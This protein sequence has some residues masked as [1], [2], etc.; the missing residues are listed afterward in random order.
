M[1]KEMRNR[2]GLKDRKHVDIVWLAEVIFPRFFSQYN[3]SFEVLPVE[4]M[5]TNHGL[6]N[7]D[8]GKVMIREDVYDRAC[9]GKG[10]DR[11]TIAHELGHFLMH[12]GMTF[13]LARASK[14]E[15][16]PPYCDPE[17]QATAF[18]AEFLMD[19]DIIR[20]MSPEEIAKECGVSLEA[21]RYQK[22]KI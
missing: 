10:R 20:N 11:L 17:W 22:G 2:L 13:G 19:S 16:I 3:Y 18:A 6:T 5:G 4:E 1:A 14:D 9:Q 7:P 15:D 21:A 8:T 12:D